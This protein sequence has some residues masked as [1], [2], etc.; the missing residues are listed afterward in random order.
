MDGFSENVEMHARLPA[1]L[2]MWERV[3]D[4]SFPESQGRIGFS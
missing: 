2:N 3:V 4:K 1:A